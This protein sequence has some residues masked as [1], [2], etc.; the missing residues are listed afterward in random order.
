MEITRELA[1]QILKYCDKNKDFYFPF[2]VM[3]KEYTPENDDFVEICPDEWEDMESDPDYKTF[4]LWEN[5]QDLH[6]CT[7]ELLA[8]GFIEKIT[9]QSIER[10]LKHWANEYRKKWKENLGENEKILDYGFNE[11]L[12][13]KAEGFEEALLIVKKYQG[14]SN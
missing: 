14:F 1:I 9:S 3:C 7:T 4:Q 10:Q 12:E 13:G 6:N 5:L 8:R 11:F 2:F